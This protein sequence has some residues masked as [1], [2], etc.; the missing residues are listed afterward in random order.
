MDFIERFFHLSP[1]GGNGITEILF[2][3]VP[4]LAVGIVLLIRRSHPQRP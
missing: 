3:L 1:D 4:F 2:L